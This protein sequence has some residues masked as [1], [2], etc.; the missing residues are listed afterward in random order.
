VQVAVIVPAYNEERAIARVVAELVSLD[1]DAEVHV[2]DN[3]STD[4]TADV[5]QRALAGVERGHLHLVPA[6]GKGAAVR[7]AFTHIPASAYVLIDADLSYPVSSIPEVLRLLDGGCPMAVGDRISNG[8]YRRVHGRS[9]RLLANL[10]MGRVT[11]LFARQRLNDPLS[12][13]RALDG[14]FVRS[15]ALEADGFELE[16]ELLF[17]VARAGGRIAELPVAYRGR[18]AGQSSKLDAL[19]D[20]WRI[21]SYLVRSAARYL[22]S[23]RASSP[24]RADAPRSS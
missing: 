18:P 13:L 6:R 23:A 14:A 4:G 8:A 7:W 12:G 19:A 22:T 10:A 17:R 5:A 16:T 11:S 9:F 24:Q 20:G 21:A 1:L 15:F 3:G 2:I